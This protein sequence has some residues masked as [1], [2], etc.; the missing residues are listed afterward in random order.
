AHD[1][2]ER[3]RWMHR[4]GEIYEHSDPEN[5]AL[6]Y[7]SAL[8][9]DPRRRDS[10]H[11]LERTYRT[12]GQWDALAKALARHAA[13]I[14]DPLERAE[15]EERTAR[16]F[17]GQGDRDAAIRHHARALGLDPERTDAFQA[18]ER[19]YRELG[20]FH[21]I[22]E[23][24]E[25]GVEREPQFAAS[26][27]A[28]IAAIQ[29][30]DLQD[31]ASALATYQRALE[32]PANH[33]ATV[34]A[35][36]RAAERAGD[37]RQL[38]ELLDRE[39]SMVSGPTR[40]HVMHR[41]A[42]VLEHHLDGA[43]TALDRYTLILG[44]DPTHRPTLIS[45]EGLCAKLGKSQAFVLE[46]RLACTHDARGQAELHLRLA[47]GAE[48]ANERKKALAEFKKAIKADPSFGFAR[49]QLLDALR[50]RGDAKALVKALRE[51]MAR[52]EAPAARADL[53]LE[54]AEACEGRLGDMGSAAA[55]LEQA[56]AARSD[57][58]V[59]EW[60]TRLRGALNA[61]TQLV[62]QLERDASSIEDAPT[63][64]R[65]WLAAGH[66]WSGPLDRAERAIGAYEA[67]L[68]VEPDN[69]E[70]LVA[71]EP[72][73]RQAQ[74]KR[75]VC[76]IARML[77]AEA[78]DERLKLAM[79]DECARFEEEPQAKRAAL[80]AMLALRPDHDS[81]LEA[82]EQ[83]ALA[84]Q[85][86]QLLAVIDRRRADLRDPALAAAHLTRLGDTLASSDPR[87]AVEAYRAAVARDPQSLSAMRGL[88][89][90]AAAVGNAQLAVDAIEREAS[91]LTDPTATADR[92]V[93]AAWLRRSQLDDREGALDNLERALA[94][95]PDHAQAAERLA[96]LL[97]ELGQHARL[98]DRLGRAAH[99]CNE[100]ARKIAL[101]QL[102]ARAQLD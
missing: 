43:E 36:Q 44:E 38:L 56:L 89:V 29:E 34:H 18:L 54:L 86:A 4:L 52:Q 40:L 96:A 41:A 32:H 12:L 64:A 80:E 93:E 7:E 20:R 87:A 19:T 71:L 88:A 100:Q 13:S 17:E 62:E 65:K 73:V 95:D 53:A 57:R 48:Q 14:E 22:V 70:A 46:R 24:H 5:S 61:Q 49:M 8:T 10:L 76:E 77:A 101:W 68:A 45:L 60:L 1:D 51:E 79:L 75:R 21:E 59:S 31:P 9:N 23:L 25:R 55:A 47:Q 83:L 37:H 15:L 78:R 90:T 26:H 97:A 84:S 35:A 11:G 72:L 69:L 58:F 74:D 50:Q 42:Q 39:A 98:V 102:V 66:L 30:R 99:N 94:R 63:S 82:L 27:L 81:A 33:L 92:L 6:W 85:D 2:D 3:A 91:W 28:D 16:A 67:V